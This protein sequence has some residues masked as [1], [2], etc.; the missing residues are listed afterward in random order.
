MAAQPPP[1][2]LSTGILISRVN[3]GFKK[4]KLLPPRFF[5]QLEMC[6]LV[7]YYFDLDVQFNSYAV[8][9]KSISVYFFHGGWGDIRQLIDYLL[10]SCYR[11]L[12]LY[13][14]LKIHFQSMSSS[15]VVNLF[16][17]TY[18]HPYQI[19]LKYPFI[20]A[21]SDSPNVMRI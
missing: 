18:P 6:I 16:C 1:V 5:V 10:F 19:M 21:T 14:P 12:V 7:I 20:K 9:N 11:I 3:N 2:N 13:Q 4:F 8:S 17:L 15:V